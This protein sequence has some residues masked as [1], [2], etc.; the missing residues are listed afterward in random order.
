MSKVKVFEDN[1]KKKTREK[2]EG[3]GIGNPT[4]F[5][6]A[7]KK[8]K[9]VKAEIGGIVTPAEFVTAGGKGKLAK[10]DVAKVSSMRRRKINKDLIASMDLDEMLEASKVIEMGLRGEKIPTVMSS[11]V[12]SYVRTVL[13]LNKKECTKSIAKK[14]QQDLTVK[15]I[16]L[17]KE[18]TNV[19]VAKKLY[20]ELMN[21]Q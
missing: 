10:T 3:R 18:T 6:T 12:R 17:N 21:E 4:E 2:V 1:N 19:A 13:R 9:L 11:K 8:G 15:I 16:E 20:H 5:V 7:G 14:M